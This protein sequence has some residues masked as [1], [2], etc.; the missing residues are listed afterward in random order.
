VPDGTKTTD[1]Q[2]RLNFQFR[3]M[4]QLT[5]TITPIDGATTI[6]PRHAAR[7]TARQWVLHAALF[8]VTGF[9]TTICG[10]MMAGPELDA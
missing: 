6:T 10:I 1:C 5:E 7:P 8:M 4:S 9:S 2:L 3:F